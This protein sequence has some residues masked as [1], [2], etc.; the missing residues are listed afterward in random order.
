MQSAHILLGKPS[1][2]AHCVNIVFIFFRKYEVIP[3]MITNITALL[4]PLVPLF[5]QA[6]H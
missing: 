4:L 5:P 6:V 2:S 1:F 3:K